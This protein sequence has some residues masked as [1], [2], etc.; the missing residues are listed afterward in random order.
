VVSYKG[1]YTNYFTDVKK[2]SEGNA[3]KMEMVTKLPHS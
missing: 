3:A 2:Y 1:P